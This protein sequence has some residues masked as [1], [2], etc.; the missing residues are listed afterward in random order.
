MELV[1]E[2]LDRVTDDEIYP[3]ITKLDKI[4]TITYF[5]FLYIFLLLGFLIVFQ[6]LNLR[7]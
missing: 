2:T 6:F 3:N 7:K 1:I 5:Y 4:K